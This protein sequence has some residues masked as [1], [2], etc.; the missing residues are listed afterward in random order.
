[1]IDM[2]PT[3]LAANHGFTYVFNPEGGSN[4]MFSDYVSQDEMPKALL[5]II[6]MM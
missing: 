1:M 3:E 6:K 5:L 2:Q 4:H